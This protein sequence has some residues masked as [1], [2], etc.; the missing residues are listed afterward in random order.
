MQA[1]RNVTY[2]I[3]VKFGFEKNTSLIIYTCLRILGI[4]N[5]SVWCSTIYAS[6][7]LE[8]FCKIV[9]FKVNTII[10]ICIAELSSP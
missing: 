10:L 9:D 2:L 3:F 5:N 1:L 7:N 6:K 8:Y 4:Q